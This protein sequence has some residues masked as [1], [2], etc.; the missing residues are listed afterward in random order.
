VI[1]SSI[2]DE[3]SATQ[4]DA[5]VIYFYC[6]NNDPLRSHF[7]DIVKSLISQILQLNPNC[8]DFIY[9]SMLAGSERRAKDASKLLQIL[10]HILANHDSLYI[11]IDGLDECSEEERKLLLNLITVSSRGDDAQGNVRI[12]VASR[13]E[14]DLER[15][16]KLAAKLNIEPHNLE[17][18][19]IAYIILK[20]TQLSQRFKFTQKKEQR[21][22]NEICTRPKGQSPSRNLV[23][24]LILMETN[25]GMFLLARL[26]MD[27]LL[28]QD[29][30]EDL[31]EELKFE[32]L[33]HGINEAYV[34]F[35]SKLET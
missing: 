30:R 13:Q 5:Q 20:M 12:I 3:I 26:I 11:G 9:E 16:L 19:I 31:E 8:L 18:D 2:I 21:L 25:T 22:I 10:D 14:K 24:V 1:F 4:P 35:Q 27:N 33:P 34:N 17:N 23:E 32:V 6:K 28:S 7:T 29:N 15:S